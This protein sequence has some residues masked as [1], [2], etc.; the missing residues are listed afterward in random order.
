MRTSR[1]LCEEIAAKTPLA[2]QAIKRTINH[3][4]ERGLDRGDAVRRRGAAP[5]FVSDDMTEGYQATAEKRPARFE[6][7]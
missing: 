3:W 5:N 6:G 1:A 2:V 4:S 7:K